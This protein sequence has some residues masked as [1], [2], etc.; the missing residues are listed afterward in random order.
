MEKQ[1]NLLEFICLEVTGITAEVAWVVLFFE[2]TRAEVL[3]A[4]A[5]KIHIISEGLFFKVDLF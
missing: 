5:E 3:F 4:I 2:N 1:Y